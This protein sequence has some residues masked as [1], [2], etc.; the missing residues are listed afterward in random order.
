MSA[1]STYLLGIALAALAAAGCAGSKAETNGSSAGRVLQGA[2]RYP[3]EGLLIIKADLNQDSIPDVYSIYKEEAGSDGATT[4]KL[5]RKEIDVNFDGSVDIWRHYN[6]AERLVK[7]ELD[8]NFDGRVDAVNTFDQGALV[9]KEV[10]VEFDQAP[11]IFKT[12]KGGELVRVERD[13]NNDGKIDLW[14]YYE[15][16]TLSRV[17]RDQDGDGQVETWQEQ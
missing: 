6:E 2:D 10:D 12:Y 7:E 13:T 1:R 3:N 11:D 17:G 8:Y 14:E 5:V 9:R 4:R 15:R 16:G